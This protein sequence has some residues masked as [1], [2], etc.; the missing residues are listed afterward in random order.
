MTIC[1]LHSFSVRA[2]ACLL[3][4]L[5]LTVA[6]AQE[7]VQSPEPRLPL[8]LPRTVSAVASGPTLPDGRSAGLWA[9]GPD[10]KVSFHDGMTF[11][12]YVGAELPHQPVHWRT[13]SVRAGEQ[14]LLAGPAAPAPRVSG[15]RCE[16]DLGAVVERYDLT[17]DGLE[18]SF[19][20]DRRPAAGDLVI[21]GELTTP[22]AVPA[23]APLHG[24]LQLRLADGRAVVGYGAAVAIDRDG[25]RTPVTTATDGNHVVL[26]VA[27]ET[28]ATAA[29]PL[30]IDPLIG[31]SLEALGNTFD[32]LDVLTET[33]T[34][35]AEQARLWFTFTMT[36]A[37]G[38]RDIYL[39]RVDSDFGGSATENYHEFSTWDASGG[40][41]ALAPAASRVVLVYGLDAGT[42]SFAAVHSHH[43]IDN[44]VTT[45]LVFVPVNP[46]VESD[47]RPDVGGRTQASG[48]SKVLIVFQREATVPLSN[49]ANS[50]V[51]ATVFDASVFP[52][53]NAFVVAPFAVLARPNA[54]QERPR[55]NQAA[56]GNNWLV[57]FQ[58]INNNVANDDWDV[59]TVAISGAGA[60]IETGL[61]TAEAGDP[62]V[63]TIT[64]QVAGSGGRYLLTYTTRAFE[65]PNPKPQGQKG[66]AVH[67][68]RLD[69]N[70]T[71]GT[72]S[73][74]HPETTMLSVV[75]NVLQNGGS[76]YD[77]TSDSHWSVGLSSDNPAR[78]RVAK[79]GYTGSI[80]ETA[81]ISLPAGY[82]PASFATTFQAAERRFPVLY[83]QNSAGA[84]FAYGAML[85]YEVVAPPTLLGV[86]CG[87]GVW[88]GLPVTANH[89]AIG[90]EDVP[91]ALANAPIDTVALL[92]L[93]TAQGNL[94][95]SLFGADGCTLVPDILTS[96][97][98]G[99][100]D[101][102]IV[103]GAAALTLDLP[104]F[105]A[106]A[107][108]IMQWVY[109]VPGANPLGA[110]A[111]EGLSLQLGR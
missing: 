96:A 39:W 110:Q 1:S 57:A 38:D 75:N 84:G 54:D 26:R 64:P 85:E 27:A 108:L 107:T 8:T 76:A 98:L 73:L 41:L 55:V 34:D 13:L 78:Y 94:P 62:L 35:P 4:A 77:T 6:T 105:L 15:T 51:W 47:W 16:Y 103:G 31:N 2:A 111:S 69:W 53:S 33:L 89:Q 42:S 104:E 14:E 56:I 36:V 12:P 74:P 81:A 46:F 82:L 101:A 52:Q 87:S 72:G 45:S 17:V 25:V 92:F 44:H 99:V 106:P 83:V 66:N 3:G 9:A 102:P 49:T 109:F 65:L 95:G 30:V 43:T 20:I 29:F 59:T 67:A 86:A 63:H 21:I 60:A 24:D 37:A 80:V 19:V 10:Y 5:P 7:T 70:H 28:V 71:A 40:Q 68:Q 61:E 79:L 93:S 88:S 18:Q 50:A 90:T 97:Y 100:L 91:L 11:Y 23:T 58:E 22:L 32:D 48:G